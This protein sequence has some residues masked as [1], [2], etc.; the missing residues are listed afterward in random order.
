MARSRRKYKKSRPKV[1]VGLPRKKPGIFKPTFTIPEELL[2]LAAASSDAAGE[3]KRIWDDKGSYLQNYRTFGVVANPNL[4]GVRARVSAV[5]QCA[6]LQLP[7]YDAA[8][9]L[10]FDSIDSG[11]D[12]ESEGWF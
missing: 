1:R 11:S 3:E 9:V 4:L 5:V 7:N 10:E 12:L 6:E 2:S 8:P